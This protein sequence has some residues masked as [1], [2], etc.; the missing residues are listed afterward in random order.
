M[1]TAAGCRLTQRPGS[2]SPADAGQRGTA[3]SSSIDR[4]MAAAKGGK[5]PRDDRGDEKRVVDGEAMR[6][7]RRDAGRATRKI[8]EGHRDDGPGLD[9]DDGVHDDGRLPDPDIE[10]IRDVEQIG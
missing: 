3:R 6:E 4:R 10:E 9:P 7:A 1:S 2:R 5:L 8:V